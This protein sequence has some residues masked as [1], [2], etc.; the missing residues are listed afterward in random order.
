MAENPK[1][2][3]SNAINTLPVRI[4]I[5]YVGALVVVLSVLS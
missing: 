5:F 1:Q 2:T 3:L 4:A